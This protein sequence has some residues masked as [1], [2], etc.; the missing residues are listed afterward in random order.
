MRMTTM[1]MTMMITMTIMAKETKENS[2][3]EKSGRIARQR[4]TSHKLTH[5]APEMFVG[6]FLFLRR[7]F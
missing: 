4:G 3:R 6:Y 5:L 2:T 1:A 7:E